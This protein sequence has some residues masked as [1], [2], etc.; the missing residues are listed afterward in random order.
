MDAQ[1]FRSVNAALALL[2][3][4]TGGTS[5]EVAGVVERWSVSEADG[6]KEWMNIAGGTPTTPAGDMVGTVLPFDATPVRFAWASLD[7]APA[8][9]ELKVTRVDDLLSG[10][11]D[12]ATFTLP[13]TIMGS[14]AIADGARIPAGQF[15]G[16]RRVGGD[17]LGWGGLYVSVELE[18]TS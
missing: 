7:G 15:F 12:V 13:T 14:M 16:L 8:E 1:W 3:L 11:D 9:L 4:R 5:G 2:A 17:F 6:A 18:R 10:L